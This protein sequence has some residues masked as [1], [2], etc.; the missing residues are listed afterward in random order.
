MRFGSITQLNTEAAQAAVQGTVLVQVSE[1]NLRTTKNGKPY[2]DIVLADVAGTVSFKVWDN[3]PW[4]PTFDGC[5]VGDAV[6]ITARWMQGQYGMEVSE[7]E[8]RPLSPEEEQQVLTGGPELLEFQQREWNCILSY[9]EQ[10]RDP[11]LRSLCLLFL[12]QQEKRFRRAAAARGYHHARR[13]GLVEHTASVMRVADAIAAPYAGRVNRDL[14]LAGALFHDAGK[15]VE[16]DYREHSLEMPYSDA[17]ELLGHIPLGIEMVNKAWREMM[18][19]AP[20]EWKQLNPPSEQVRLHLLHLVAAHHGSL[21]YGSPVLPKVPEALLLH[22]ADNIDAKM[23][24][25]RA[26]YES[27]PALSEHVL[28]RKAPLPANVLHRLPDVEE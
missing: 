22:H 20:A 21:E 17:G 4:F 8:L 3:A 23:E 14:L 10:L 11:R 5:G 6:A 26:A 15:I 24:M 18:A 16:N 27:A 1:K 19:D 7:V 12:Q 2:L 25:F 13:G 28:Q 9:A